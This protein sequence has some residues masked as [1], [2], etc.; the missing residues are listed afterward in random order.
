MYFKHIKNPCCCISVLPTA[1]GGFRAWSW[2]CPG[3]AASGTC[4]RA[5]G[6]D[7]HV[8]GVSPACFLGHCDG[9]ACSQPSCCGGCCRQHG[10]KERARRV[11]LARVGCWLCIPEPRDSG[12]GLIFLRQEWEGRGNACPTCVQRLLRSRKQKT[13]TA[14]I[15]NYY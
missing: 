11:L 2:L 1:P 4:L 10:S 7:R 12:S 14:P 15:P 9:I 13:H 8:T 3:Q 5:G 6:G